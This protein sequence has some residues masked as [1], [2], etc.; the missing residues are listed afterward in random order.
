LRSLK[1]Y[2]SAVGWA[3]GDEDDRTSVWR[4]DRSL[5]DELVVVLPAREDF[6]D[7]GQLVYE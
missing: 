2:L 1:E 3:M 7:Y 4:P 5:T 6:R